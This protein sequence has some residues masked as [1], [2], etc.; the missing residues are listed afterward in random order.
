[1]ETAELNGRPTSR[2]GFGGSTLGSLSGRAAERLLAAAFEAGIRHFDV[3]PMYAFGHSE[4]LLRSALGAWMDEITVTTKCGLSPPRQPRWTGPLRHLARKAV[5]ALPGVRRPRTRPGA[6]ED[7]LPPLTAAGVAASLEESR[8]RLG[9]SQLDV[10]LL[11][12]A[13]PGRLS[14]PAL[15]ELLQ[16]EHAAGRLR[17]FG[18]GSQR[19]RVLACLRERPQF[20]PLIQCEWNICTPPDAADTH[21]RI[22]HGSVGPV[23]EDLL[24]WLHN[25]RSRLA[26]W[27]DQLGLDLSDKGLLASLLLR[28]SLTYNAGC[29]VLFS[30][31]SVDRLQAN[32]RAAE[33]ASLLKPANALRELALTEFVPQTALA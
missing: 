27:S 29:I 6:Q 15:L 30:V 25:E 22:V 28:A 24:A 26:R 12:E 17:S 11:H 5:A 33:D 2:L 13:T 19:E 21:R 10:L 31:R 23:L 9:R 4:K 8:R 32:I 18:V 16:N 14:D 7:S 20:C 1:M 3:A